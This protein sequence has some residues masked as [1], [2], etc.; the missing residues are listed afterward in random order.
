MNERRQKL[1]ELMAER[2][3][4]GLLLVPG[5]DMTYLTGF[6]E[7]QSDRPIFFVI[8]DSEWLIAPEIYEEQLRSMEMEGITLEIW[9]EGDLDGCYELLGS[10]LRGKVAIDDRM[11]FSSFNEMSKRVKGG[12]IYLPASSLIRGMRM[13]KD[14]DEVKRLREASR[15]AYESLRAISGDIKDLR[16]KREIEVAAE[17]EYEMKRRGC[18]PSFETI[19][20]SGANSAMPHARPGSGEV[21]ANLVLDFGC[22]YRN[23]SSD[24]TRTFIFEQ[25]GRLERIYKVVG[26]AQRRAIEVVGEGVKA[27]EV[28]RVARDHITENGWGDYFIHRT[29]HGIGL[30][31]HEEPQ[32]SKES[33]TVLKAGMV[34]SVEPGIYIPGKYGVRIEDVVV[35]TESG[36]EVL[37][38]C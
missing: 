11:S 4:E 28:D 16:G 27:K 8:G 7:E 13:V 36:C 10:M 22:F 20:A 19:A 33:E 29:G 6:R 5:P 1:R 14:G 26:E 37:G 30:E 23:Y 15:I 35:V 18:P 21:G 3:F 34:F 17:L 24:M 38:G 32:I 31:V 2:G 9:K 12:H 25:D